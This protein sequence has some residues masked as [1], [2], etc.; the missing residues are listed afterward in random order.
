V[1]N[2][3]TTVTHG[4]TFSAFFERL[5][6]QRERTAVARMFKMTPI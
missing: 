4:A 3:V 6:R 2:T 5:D 1:D